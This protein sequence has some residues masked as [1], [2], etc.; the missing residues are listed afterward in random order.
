MFSAT[1]F[2]IPESW[3]MFQVEDEVKGADFNL[4]YFCCHLSNWDPFG[5][6]EEFV[7]KNFG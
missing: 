2:Q 1:N 4:D 7:R 3:Y 5:F 6:E